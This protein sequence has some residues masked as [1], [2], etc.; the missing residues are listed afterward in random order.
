[1]KRGF[2]VHAGGGFGDGYERSVQELGVRLYSL[3]ISR[4]AINPPADIRLVLSLYRLYR[5]EKPNVV[6]H[7]TIKPVIYGSVA[8]KLAGVKRIVNT[9]PGLGYVFT[10][11]DRVVLRK[12]VEL[13]YRIALF[14]SDV[15]FFQNQDDMD[16]FVQKRL[17]SRN[18]ARRLPGSGVDCDR[19]HPRHTL[20][21]PDRPITF[22]MVSRLL[23][24][25][26]IYEFVRAAEKVKRHY[27]ETQ[28]QLLGFRDVRNPNVIP[29]T[30]LDCWKSEGK[31]EWL[32]GVEDVRP[33]IGAAD[34]IVLPS[35][36]REGIPRALLEAAAMEI[37]IVTS[38]SVGC[39][40]VVADGINGILV[41]KRNPEQLSRAM[42]KLIENPE[43]RLKMGQAGR[44]RMLREF[45]EKAVIQETINQY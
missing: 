38:D 10:E 1:L 17:V 15:T 44:L 16:Y 21:K 12:V 3:P 13:L 25:K 30:D 39:R 23:K 40:E 11:Q 26:G 2:E 36:Y 32:G 33:Y 4:H 43:L 37:P 14:C 29:R 18:V 6:H 9:I 5:A 42:I 22:L 35:Y 28:F 8:A 27:P 31:M 20:P 45:D 7:F 34:V 24:E 41:P 19:F